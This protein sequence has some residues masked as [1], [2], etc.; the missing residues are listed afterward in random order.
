MTH[1]VCLC[2]WHYS[3]LQHKCTYW[4]SDGFHVNADDYCHFPDEDAFNDV[5]E[6]EDME[7]E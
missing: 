3:P 6:F 5:C 4:R 7:D 2:C 1:K